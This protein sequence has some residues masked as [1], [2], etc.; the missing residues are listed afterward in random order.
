MK[1]L[2]GSAI[3]K[4]KN[5]KITN[6]SDLPQIIINCINP[7][8]KNNGN[9]ISKKNTK[10]KKIEENN[11]NSLKLDKPKVK[12]NTKDSNFHNFLKLDCMV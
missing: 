10:R 8:T 6:L 3:A 7:T 4:S 1:A 11:L 2:S 12:M 9:N 5:K